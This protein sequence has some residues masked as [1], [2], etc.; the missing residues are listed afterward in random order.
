MDNNS[1]IV[2][3]SAIF[4]DPG[5]IPRSMDNNSRPVNNTAIFLDPWIIKVG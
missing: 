1:R 2:N 5:H 3:N 4:L